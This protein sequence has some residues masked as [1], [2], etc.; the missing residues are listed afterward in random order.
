MGSFLKKVLQPCEE[1]K[2]RKLASFNFKP[3]NT[4]NGE[5]VGGVVSL[6]IISSQSLIL[7]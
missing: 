6:T 4:G 1:Q 2:V 3:L 7:S 5:G